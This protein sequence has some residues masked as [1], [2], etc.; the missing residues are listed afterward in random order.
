MV[1]A[2]FLESAMEVMLPSW[3]GPSSRG[4]VRRGRAD[5]FPARVSQ[6]TPGY[7]AGTGFLNLSAL[8]RCLFCTAWP[9][10]EHPLGLAAVEAV[11]VF[12]TPGQPLA[13]WQL[14]TVVPLGATRIL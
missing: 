1:V 12:E 6:A 13:T 2:F 10:A 5:I 9:Q 7:G 14:T 8:P 4:H 3:L 11:V